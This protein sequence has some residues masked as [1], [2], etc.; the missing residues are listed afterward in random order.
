MPALVKSNVGSLAGTS[1]DECTR[2][3]PLLSKKRRN[4]SRISEPVSIILI[5][6]NGATLIGME[7]SGCRSLF[8]PGSVTSSK[9]CSESEALVAQRFGFAQIRKLV[10]LALFVC[11]CC[12]AQDK[13]ELGKEARSVSEWGNELNSS[14]QIK[15]EAHLMTKQV[16]GGAEY[17]FYDFYLTGAPADQTYTIFQWPLGKPQP[18]PVTSAYVSNNGRLCMHAT[19]CHDTEGPYVMLALLSFPGLPHRIGIASEDKKF[20]A[21]ALV[22]PDPI[23][24]TDKG[25][26]VE[27]IRVREDFSLT[28]V[29]GKGFQLD[30]EI[31]YT[32]NSEGEE[33]KGSLKAD[34]FGQFSFYLGPG[35]K[36][37]TKGTAK[38]DFKAPGCAPSVSFHWAPLGE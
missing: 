10:V 16:R 8:L 37:K 11:F 3:C 14:A 29:R 34:E 5:V 35:V 27:V 20:K 28:V 24:G 30:K 9:V 21:V 19:G 22:V 15:L 18:E 33:I 17:G 4:F 2:L 1:D 6:T 23:I 25:C 38:I 7:A 32:S 13:N 31:I 12:E 26:S 36:G